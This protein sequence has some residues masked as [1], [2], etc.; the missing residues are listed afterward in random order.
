M[1]AL[2]FKV[3][4]L[5][6]VMGQKKV[7][8]DRLKTT[9]IADNF[10]F[11]GM[12]FSFLLCD[13]CNAITCGSIPTMAERNMKGYGWLTVTE[14]VSFNGYLMAITLSMDITHKILNAILRKVE[15]INF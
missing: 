11:F 8:L 13:E 4:G 5:S 9:Q 15:L 1:Q 10:I 2:Q 3:T 12:I 6:S 14:N 7:F